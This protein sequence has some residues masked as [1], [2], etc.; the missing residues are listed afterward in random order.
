MAVAQEFACRR[1]PWQ[2]RPYLL[3]AHVLPGSVEGDAIAYTSN[4]AWGAY[5][6]MAR[7]LFTLQSNDGLIFVATTPPMSRCAATAPGCNDQTTSP[8]T[9]RTHA[10]TH[11]PTGMDTDTSATPTNGSM[12]RSFGSGGR[13]RVL[14]A[15]QC[16]SSA[17]YL[18]P[19]CIAA[20][21]RGMASSEP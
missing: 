5:H 2:V 15:R 20:F 9:R 4:S 18:A 7:T 21:V 14:G 19:S 1:R 17:M 12:W 10:H 16:P 11:T 13:A 8:P 6:T 3:V